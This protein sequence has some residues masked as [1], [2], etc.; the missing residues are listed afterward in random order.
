MTGMG[1]L[2]WKQKQPTG[3]RSLETAIILDGLDTSKL[4]IERQGI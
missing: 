1:T 3:V 2:I 4:Y